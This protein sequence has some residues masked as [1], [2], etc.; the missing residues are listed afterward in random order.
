MRAGA[1]NIVIGLAGALALAVL[2]AHPAV[3]RLEQRLGISVLTAVGLPFLVFG[4]LLALPSVGVLTPVVLDDLRPAVNIGL[5]WIG[6]V[7]GLQFDLRWWRTLPEGT[8][9][10]SLLVTLPALVAALS[11]GALTLLAAGVP[12]ESPVLLRDALILAGCAAAAAPLAAHEPAPSENNRRLQGMTL[13]SEILPLAALA[14]ATMIYRPQS[15]VAWGALPTAVWVLL[16]L[17]LGGLCGAI[18]YL[19]LRAASTEAERTAL[20]LGSVALASGTASHL[21]LPPAFLGL[22]AGALLSNLPGGSRS[23]LRATMIAVERPLYLIFLLVAGATWRPG[24]WQGW[25][26]AVVIVAARLI[27][28]RLGARWLARARPG[29]GTPAAVA[30]TFTPPSPVAIVAIVG[31]SVVFGGAAGGTHNWAV[32]AVIIGGVLSE[33]AA[34]A[35]A[36]ARPQ[37]LAVPDEPRVPGSA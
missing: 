25:M 3:R 35:L 21:A 11:L 28:Y 14:A 19:L 20:L 12:L 9:N 4:A 34:R 36:P 7:V 5:A 17:G 16:S 24:E 31:A 8:A 27:G 33:I 2:A 23:P 30:A 6:F 1:P 15:T 26:L 32:N 22:V 37:Q 10:D 29:I 13:I 18:S